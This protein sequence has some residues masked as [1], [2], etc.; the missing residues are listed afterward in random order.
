MTDI[1]RA[2]LVLVN[3]ALYPSQRFNEMLKFT[4]GLTRRVLS[5]RLQELECEG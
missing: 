4:S 3:M 5:M 2:M 1:D